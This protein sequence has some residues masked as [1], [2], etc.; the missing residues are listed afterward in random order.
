[1]SADTFAPDQPITRAQFVAICARFAKTSAQGRTFDDVPATHWAADY[2]STAAS[3]GWVN[4]ISDTEF[5]PDRA[6]TRAEAAAMVNRVLS[7]IPD[8]GYI[9]SQPQR[10]ADVEKLNWAWYDIS[11]AF[12]GE[13]PR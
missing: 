4:G 11:E 8:R 6:I 9:D 10:Y 2:I 5:A 1:M 7:R 13:L 12:F 3:Y